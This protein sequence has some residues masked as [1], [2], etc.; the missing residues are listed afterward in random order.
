LP[1]KHSLRRSHR[2]ALTA[3]A[4]VGLAVAATA[5]AVGAPIQ[6]GEQWPVGIEPKRLPSGSV[7]LADRLA[8]A[9]L[10]PSHLDVKAAR[11]GPEVGIPAA[12]HRQ[13]A[14]A[15]ALGFDAAPSQARALAHDVIL[16]PGASSTCLLLVERGTLTC[17][18]NDKINK[19]GLYT[20]L[21]RDGIEDVVGIV[22]DGVREVQQVDAGGRAERAALVERNVFRVVTATS[23]PEFRL[24][25]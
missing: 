11:S 25:R 17:E 4:I 2:L 9:R 6:A 10:N 7:R 13:L 18:T 14:E 5:S 3:T 15:L 8:A 22:P 21:V 16:I 1:G 12:F 20:S 23:H 19:V 24:A